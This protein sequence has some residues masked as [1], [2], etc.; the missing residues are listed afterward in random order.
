MISNW[1]RLP[2]SR[3]PHSAA[4]SSSPFEAAAT[5]TRQT[6]GPTVTS[7]L[8][9]PASVIPLCKSIN[10][11]TEPGSSTILFIEQS[12][13]A[14]WA[15]WNNEH[16]HTTS[17]T[18]TKQKKAH[19]IS[20]SL[21]WREQT[22]WWNFKHSLYFSSSDMF[23][24][25]NKYHRRLQ[26][27]ARLQCTKLIS[28]CYSPKVF[29]L[30]ISNVQPPKWSN[31]KENTERSKDGFVFAIYV[32]LACFNVFTERSIPKLQGPTLSKLNNLIM[33]TLNFLFLP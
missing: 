28:L 2:C 18:K 3:G 16:A 5:I 14:K 27:T 31:M 19:K 1:N 4:D 10:L 23:W 21:L 11:T 20:L 13:E 7:L 8:P 9:K 30:F 6:G 15:Y 24:K 25:E 12:R 17:D 33:I 26:S 32:N 22:H 29:P